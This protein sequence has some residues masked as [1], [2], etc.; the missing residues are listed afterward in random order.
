MIHVRIRQWFYQTEFD[1]LS[2]AIQ[3]WKK[4]TICWITKVEIAL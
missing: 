4:E 1:P 3:D 2:H